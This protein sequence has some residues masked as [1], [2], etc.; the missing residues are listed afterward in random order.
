MSLPKAIASGPA[1]S[2]PDAV[3]PVRVAIGAGVLAALYLFVLFVVEPVPTRVLTVYGGAKNDVER[4][5]GLEMQWQPPPGMTDKEIVERFR[6]G[7][8]RAQLR[9]DGDAYVISFPRVQRDQV[10]DTAKFLGGE[11]GL[12][13]HRVLRVKEMQE[14]ARLLELPMRNAKPVD[15]DVDQWRPDEGGEMRTDYFLIGERWEDIDAKLAEA[16]A[17]GWQLPEGTRIA[18]ENLTTERGVLWRTYVIDERVE[19]DGGD[20]ENALGSYDPNTNRPIVLLDFTRQGADKFGKLTEEIVGEKLATMIGNQVYSAP[21]INGAIR[22]GRASIT[23]GA[24]DPAQQERERDL[25]VGTLRAGALPKGGKIV[26]SGYVE[27]IDDSVQQW[28][29]RGTLALGG[30]ALI[31]LLAW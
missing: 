8:H 15:M 30:G 5:G 22:G 2:T 10:E 18:W 7:E 25:L 31:G 4:H 26:K 6:T 27:P 14:L 20:I 16:E 12:E 23:M 19:V 11:D 13:F 9:R 17:K 24:S 1:A 29:A 28:L 3:K 21:I